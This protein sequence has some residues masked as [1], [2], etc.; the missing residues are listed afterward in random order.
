MRQI[1]IFLFPLAVFIYKKT[2]DSPLPRDVDRWF[3]GRIKRFLGFMYF[4]ELTCLV[5]ILGEVLDGAGVLRDHLHLGVGLV[6][7]V[8]ALG[9]H[10]AVSLGFLLAVDE[11]TLLALC[12]CRVANLLK[13]LGEG[14]LDSL[15][16]A[17]HT[18][19]DSDEALCDVGSAGSLIDV[20]GGSTAG[21]NRGCDLTE[22]SE[23]VALIAGGQVAG[24]AERKDSAAGL[25]DDVRENSVRLVTV[26]AVLVERPTEKSDFAT[27]PRR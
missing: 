17:E 1:C 3:D 7:E 27:A 20:V 5:K 11:D 16:V 8:Y 21:E 15:L 18:V 13:I 25:V 26:V 2:L 24:A 14:C 19:V 23:A 12:L 6:V 10:A 4:Q 9:E 22:H